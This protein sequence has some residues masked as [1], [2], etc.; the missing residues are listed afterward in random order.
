MEDIDFSSPPGP[1]EVISRY[2]FSKSKKFNCESKQ[3][4]WKHFDPLFNVKT[5]Q[6]EVSVMRVSLLDK[7]KQKEIGFDFVGELRKKNPIGCISFNASAVLEIELTVEPEIVSHPL[8]ANILGWGNRKEDVLEKVKLLAKRV[9]NDD[10][11]F[12]KY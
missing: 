11:I 8:H 1:K 2:I 12:C 6:F 5:T 3:I 4:H 7:H 10:S 9:S